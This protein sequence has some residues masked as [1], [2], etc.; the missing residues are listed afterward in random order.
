MSGVYMHIWIHTRAYVWLQYVHV[1]VCVVLSTPIFKSKLR[2]I[3]SYLSH[4]IPASSFRFILKFF[5]IA[6]LKLLA[7]PEWRSLQ[8]TF[9]SVRHHSYWQFYWTVNGLCNATILCHTSIYS[10]TQKYLFSVAVW[11]YHVPQETHVSKH[12]VPSWWH[13]LRGLRNL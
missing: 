5:V 4:R 3:I 10:H 1:H 8:A 12:M 6:I 13:W 7:S 11:M 2:T 9:S